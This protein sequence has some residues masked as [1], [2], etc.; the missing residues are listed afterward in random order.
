[1]GLAAII[2]FVP[3]LGLAG[4]SYKYGGGGTVS[5]YDDCVTFREERIA[6]DQTSFGIRE[7]TAMES[8]FGTA[9]FELVVLDGDNVRLRYLNTPDE[10]ARLFA[11]HVP[12]PSARVSESP[13]PSAASD[14]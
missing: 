11:K 3:V 10:V 7:Q 1:V 8:W 14:G 12:T 4:L 13:E 9:T 5:F 2:T 6:Y